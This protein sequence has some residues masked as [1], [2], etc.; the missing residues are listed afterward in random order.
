MEL[1]NE[2]GLYGEFAIQVKRPDSSVRIDLP[3]QKNLITD[4]G[5]K[6][7]LQMNGTLNT[8]E[9]YD[10]LPD[11]SMFN[12]CGLGTGNRAPQENDIAFHNYITQLQARASTTNTVDL[13]TVI[14][15]NGRKYIKFTSYFTYI[16]S[17]SAIENQNITEVGLMSGM[18]SHNGKNNCYIL[19]T[20]A[21]I[22]NTEGSPISISP[23]V[24]EVFELTYKLNMFV[25]ITK[26]KGEY[27]L[28]TPTGNKTM[29]YLQVPYALSAQDVGKQLNIYSSTYSRF[30]TWGSAKPEN[31][32]TDFSFDEAV[33]NN[34]SYKER[35]VENGLITGRVFA[36]TAAQSDFES[37]ITSPSYR[38]IISNQAEFA[39][40]TRTV[41]FES[42]PYS[43]NHNE[44][45][46]GFG[47]RGFA[48]SV[49]VWGNGYP[50]YWNLVVVK[51]KST[52]KAEYKTNKHKWEVTYSY[53]INRWVD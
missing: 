28:E 36:G 15:K 22:K 9:E 2:I 20:R 38:K 43:H 16:F 37:L 39:T 12:H 24:G 30:F 19:Y 35:N 6:L 44:Q 31:E 53:S 26:V 25:D 33:F 40:K 17:G 34:L 51:E 8:G 1:K 27:Q 29:E 18:I 14:E 21:L 41:T 45:R 50:L 32:V 52:G 47:I 7:Y 49:N 42:G 4:N 11:N 10:R 5:M 13:D 3:M 23:Q 46:L 48:Y